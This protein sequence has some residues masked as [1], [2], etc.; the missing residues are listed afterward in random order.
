MQHHEMYS[1]TLGG[2]GWGGVGGGAKDRMKMRWQDLIH[3][4]YPKNFLSLED[5]TA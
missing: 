1:V 3:F 5:L 4:G 2:G